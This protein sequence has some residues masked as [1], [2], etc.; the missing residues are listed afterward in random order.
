MG[1]A[2]VEMAKLARGSDRDKVQLFQSE[3]SAAV[4]VVDLVLYKKC[5]G[6]R[7]KTEL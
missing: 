4:K 3:L 6:E 7:A 1:R 2:V 5:V